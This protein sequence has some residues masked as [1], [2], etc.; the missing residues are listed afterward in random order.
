MGNGAVQ[1][2][3]GIE[4]SFHK[5]IKDMSHQPNSD[6]NNAE[7]KT[8]TV[9]LV[10]MKAIGVFTPETQFGARLAYA[11]NEL[12]LKV[13][14]LSRL[15]KDYDPAGQGVSPTSIAR[16]ES[17]DRL[18]GLGEFRILCDALDV[19]SQWLL[20]GDI[21][22]GGQNEFE[23]HLLAA[24]D[25]YIRA[26][27]HDVMLEGAPVSHYV[28]WHAQQNRAGAIEKAKKPKG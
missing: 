24:L 26:K 18:P 3:G 8:P 21:A 12:G 19:P 2:A 4:F 22:N 6:A 9:R 16:Y 13:E 23:Q 17:G 20:Y 5:N 25:G 10:P 11:R 28:A 14:A 15:S 7:I 27:G 1:R